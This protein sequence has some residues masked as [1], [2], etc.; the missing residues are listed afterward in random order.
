MVK[1]V[2]V[3]YLVIAFISARVREPNHFIDVNKMGCRGKR[4]FDAIMKIRQDAVAFGLDNRHGYEA[5]DSLPRTG[6]VEPSTLLVKGR[7]W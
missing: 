1:Y 7:W 6:V 3:R 2:N 5:K 4:S